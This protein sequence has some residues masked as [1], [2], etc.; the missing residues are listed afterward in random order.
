[1]T[2]QLGQVW[3]GGVGSRRVRKRG[4]WIRPAPLVRGQIWS[5]EGVVLLA[6]S[7]LGCP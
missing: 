5:W 1:M 6:S 2:Q 7:L 3:G 4:L